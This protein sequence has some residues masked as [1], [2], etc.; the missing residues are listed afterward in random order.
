MK[1]REILEK[2]EKETLEEFFGQKIEVPY[3]P[4]V[5]LEKIEKWEQFGFDLHYLPK[6]CVMK[7][8]QSLWNDQGQHSLDYKDFPLWK[9]KP[10]V[11]TFR[12]DLNGGYIDNT[13]MWLPGKW[14]LIDSEPKPKLESWENVKKGMQMYKNDLFSETLRRLREE[15]K[16]RDYPIKESRFG[17]NPQE[18]DLWD[19]KKVFAETLDVNV[20]TV[21]LPKYIEWNFLGNIHYKYWGDHR[22]VEW[23][24]D[25]YHY[26]SWSYQRLFGGDSALGGLSH[27]CNAGLNNC[28]SKFG[29]RYLAELS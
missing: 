5:S 15:G 17:L 29:F 26:A 6:I 16:I 18:V 22:T 9:E 12:A 25:R 3:L 1:V 28:G 19:L 14:I 24:E 10:R 2:T 23:F 4:Q 27:V 20:T 13:S 7:R 21:R 11:I 8:N